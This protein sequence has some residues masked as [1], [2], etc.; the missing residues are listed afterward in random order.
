MDIETT[1]IVG[2]EV[3]QYVLGAVSD[4]TKGFFLMPG[5]VHDFLLAHKDTAVIF[6]NA[7]FDLGVL[8]SLLQS[9]KKPM[10]VYGLVDEHKVWDTMLLHKLCTLATAGHTSQGK[11]QSTLE[12]CVQL[13]LD[14]IL[15]KDVKD[16]YGAEVRLSWSKWLG[17]PASSIDLIYLRYLALDTLCTFGCFDELLPRIMNAL[18]NAEEAFGYVDSAW[19]EDQWAR[20]G[21]QTHHLQLGAAIAL[22]DTERYGFGI[23]GVG[24]GELLVKAEGLL[25]ALREAL[26]LR[27]YL[28]G[29]KGCDKAM[30]AI[31]A[32]TLKEHPG[33]EIPKTASGK[34]YSTTEES[35]DTLAEVSEFFS[36]YKEFKAIQGLI[37]NNLAKM[38]TTRVHAHYDVLKDT[39]RTSTSGPN[40]QGFPAKKN[41]GKQAGFDIRRCFI[42]SAGKLFYVPDYSTV[43]LR[44]LSQSVMTQFK[45]DSEMARVINSGKD[46]HRIVAARMKV[47]HMPD[48]SEILADPSRFGAVV[49][50][51]TD[52]ERNGAKPANFGLPAGMGVACLKA[53][54]RVKYNQPYT[55]EEAEGW[56]AAWLASFPEM[57]PFREDNVDVA[58]LLAER[59]QMTP[60]DYSSATGEVN[61][62]TSHEQ[63]LPASWLGAMALKVL[64]QPNPCKTKSGAEYTERMLDYFWGR[65]KQLAPQLK[66]AA[67]NALLARQPSFNLCFAVKKLVNKVG[68]FTITG[69]LRAK[70]SYS[71]RRNTI[72]QGGAADGAKLALYRLWRAG[73]KVV[74][75]IHDEFVVEVDAD[76]DLVR[77]KKQ[78]DDILI[79]AMKEICP[80]MVIGVKGGFRRRWGKE[81]ADEVNLTESRGVDDGT[82]VA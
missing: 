57:V 59:L 55:D 41:K 42:P 17:Q 14:V 51:V 19:L 46:V 10:D 43:E 35:L 69:R 61:Y 8:H 66:S 38:D 23:D 21:P 48:A 77:V 49:V 62:S 7:P 50:S 56:K 29:E 32:R 68:V 31:I 15:A 44:T 39:G 11:G 22:D 82:S 58:L 36:D 26:R 20:F 30:Q 40:I 24:R 63:E 9:Q 60:A 12:K 25:G 18:Q 28:A 16:Q 33:I 45:L 5:H 72:F 78:I 80:D 52:E 27:G 73:F 47:T 70:A 4:G 3:P 1:L 54:A 75:F 53:Y 65:L 74:A 37:N 79:A 76:A 64:K 6:H 13:Y 67:Q 2:Y 34:K 81:E 71:A